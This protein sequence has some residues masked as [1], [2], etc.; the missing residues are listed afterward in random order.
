GGCV[1]FLSVIGA[2]AVGCQLLQALDTHGISTEYV[3]QTPNRRTLSEQRIIAASQMLLRLDQGSTSAVSAKEEQVLID[4]LHDLVLCCDAV[5]VSDYGYG[6]LTSPVIQALA[7]LQS[8][9]PRVLLVYSKPHL[10]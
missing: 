5:I 1:S 8:E 4:R 3:L 6:I 10:T 7:E 2:D 9:S